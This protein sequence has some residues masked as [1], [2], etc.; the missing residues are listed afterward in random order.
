[1]REESTRAWLRFDLRGLGMIN[2]ISRGTDFLLL[3]GR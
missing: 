1:M 3:P 2:N